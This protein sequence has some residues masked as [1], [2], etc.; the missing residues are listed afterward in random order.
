M[1]DLAYCQYKYGVM[2]FNTTLQQYFSYVV[3]VSVIGGGNRKYPE[4]TT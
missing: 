1:S 3:V 2:V 4:K